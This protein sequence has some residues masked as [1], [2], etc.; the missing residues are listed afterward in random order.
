MVMLWRHLYESFLSG[1]KSLRLLWMFCGCHEG[2]KK[3]RRLQGVAAV[4][5][6]QFT[7]SLARSSARK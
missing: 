6:G 3:S 2:Y 1:S 5:G 4:A 7:D